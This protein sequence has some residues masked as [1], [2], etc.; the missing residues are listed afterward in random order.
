MADTNHTVTDAIADFATLRIETLE[1][2]RETFPDRTTEQLTTLVDW[3]VGTNPE[4]DHEGLDR[5]ASCLARIRKEPVP[6]S[7]TRGAALDAVLA[8]LG[9]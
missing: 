2:L 7:G 5:A 9:H 4:L 6:T 1:R 8:Y 3:A